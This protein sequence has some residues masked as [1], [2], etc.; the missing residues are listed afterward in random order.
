MSGT[1]SGPGGSRSLERAVFSHDGTPNVS[2]ACEG[3]TEGGKAVSEEVKP[4]HRSA[5]STRRV[6]SVVFCCRGRLQTCLPPQ[7]LDFAGEEQH[8]EPAAFLLQQLGPL[9]LIAWTTART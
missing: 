8:D 9:A 2:T 3:M 5:W 4:W 6:D 1:A 7:H